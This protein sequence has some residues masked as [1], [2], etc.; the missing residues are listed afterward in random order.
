VFTARYTLSRYIKQIRFIFKGLM[1]GNMFQTPNM[2]SVSQ[3]GAGSPYSYVSP[4]G[5][6]GGPQGV[7]VGVAVVAPQPRAVGNVA[8]L[9]QARFGVA[10]GTLGMCEGRLLCKSRLM[11]KQT[12]CVVGLCVM[13]YRHVCE[14][15]G[16]LSQQPWGMGHMLNNL[17]IMLRGAYSPLCI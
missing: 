15:V 10:T 8:P 7:N 13:W 11:N 17:V 16:C 2:T 1:K 5:G 4:G 12:A 3:M 14:T 9:Q 6:S